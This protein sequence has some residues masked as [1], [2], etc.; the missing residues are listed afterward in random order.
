MFTMFTSACTNLSFPKFIKYE[1][2]SSISNKASRE[3][4]RLNELTDERYLQL[5]AAAFC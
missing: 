3:I 4:C 2:T 5:R 1:G